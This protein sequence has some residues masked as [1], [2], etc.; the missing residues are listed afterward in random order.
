MATATRTKREEL[1]HLVHEMQTLA[2][3][4]DAKGD[5]SGEDREKVVRMMAD[6]KRL[7]EEIKA[8]AEL[9]GSLDEAKGFLS[10]LAGAPTKETAADKFDLTV[11]GLPM[12]PEGKT[13]G[14]LFVESAAHGDF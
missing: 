14:E 12:R 4:A 2:D 6:V 10:Q 11:S 13:L 8:E 9:N 3:D 7:S 5:F 1:E